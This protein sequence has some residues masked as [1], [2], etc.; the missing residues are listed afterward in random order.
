[1]SE[2]TDK[3]VP[4]ITFCE[5]ILITKLSSPILISKFILNQISLA[6]EKFS[7]DYDL[8]YKI[9]LNDESSPYILIKYNEINIF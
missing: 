5:P 7:L 4:S 1:M 6:D 9:K 3:D 8:L 2:L